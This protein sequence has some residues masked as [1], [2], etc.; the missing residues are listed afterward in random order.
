MTSDIP[1]AG[2][3]FL[4]RLV[5]TPWFNAVWF[6]AIWFCTVLGRNALLPLVGCL[7]AAHILWSGE[8]RRE[9]RQLVVAGGLGISVDALLSAVGIYLFPGGELLPLWLC[10]LWLAFAATLGRCFGWLATRPLLC[11]I[12]GGVAFPLNYWA[13][14]RLGAVEF[15]AP[16]PFTLLLLALVWSLALPAM[17]QCTL[18]LARKPGMTFR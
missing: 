7:L 3:P 6:Q 17:V 5:N 4:T 11:A 2:T 16:L 12:A 15:G 9:L 10:G 8:W 1:L 14:Y 18:I 13:G